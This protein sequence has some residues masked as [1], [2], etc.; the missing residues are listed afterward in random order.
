M[1]KGKV[2]DSGTLEEWVNE[3]HKLAVTVGYKYPGFKAGEIPTVKVILTQTY[4]N[5][6]KPVVDLQLARAGIRLARVLNET[7]GAQ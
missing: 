4:V 7:L 5:K 3:S 6:A 2:S 1:K